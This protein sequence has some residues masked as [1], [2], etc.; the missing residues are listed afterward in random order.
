MECRKCKKDVEFLTLFDGSLVCPNCKNKI[1][2]EHFVVT[3]ENDELYKMSEL[4][5]HNA[6]KTDNRKLFKELI[7]KATDMCFKAVGLGHPKAILKIGFYYAHD[8]I[9]RSRSK[10]ERARYASFYFKFL[11]LSS[12]ESC[13]VEN[14]V[15]GFDN[16]VF[17]NLKKEAAKEFIEMLEN[18][19]PE[20]SDYYEKDIEYIRLKYG[21]V[22]KATEIGDDTSYDASVKILKSCYGNSHTPLFGMFKMTKN[23]FCKNAKDIAALL[24]DGKIQAL[25]VHTNTAGRLCYTN[26]ELNFS[27]IMA[28]AKDWSSQSDET[29]PD[30]DCYMFFVNKVGKHKLG[31]KM[32]KN[33]YNLLFIN[34]GNVEGAVADIVKRLYVKCVNNRAD[35]V[36]TDDDVL[37]QSALT[38]REALRNV[39][40]GI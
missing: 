27:N 33:V 24:G 6:I 14:G 38:D 28:Y 22:K 18:L 5:Y 19:P 29:D 25:I 31:G 23:E 37:A 8:Y 16:E 36:F 21:I 9:E 1:L 10:S 13:E 30:N 2:D 34:H 32:R 12:C 7:A 35:Y 26:K 17:L 20:S 4:L 15:D 3:K 11:F 40:D 39:V